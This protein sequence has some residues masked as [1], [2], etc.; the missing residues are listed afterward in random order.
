VTSRTQ[1]PIPRIGGAASDSV[2]SE[3]FK[4]IHN[5]DYL[6]E[7]ELYLLIGRAIRAKC[8]SLEMANSAEERTV[9]EGVLQAV[10][11]GEIREPGS[12][13]PY[14]R[15]MVRQQLIQTES[16]ESAMTPLQRT[17]IQRATTDAQDDKSDFDWKLQIR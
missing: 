13:I 5:R 1:T 7:A 12:L 17:D 6:A 3:L 14:V 8:M 2:Q 9:F 11:S 16:R 10:R 15:A 4:R